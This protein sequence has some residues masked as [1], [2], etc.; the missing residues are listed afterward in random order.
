MEKKKM[1]QK[2]QPA[3]LWKE[4]EGMSVVDEQVE[5]QHIHTTSGKLMNE[6]GTWKS[7]HCSTALLLPV[8]EMLTKDESAPSIRPSYKSISLEFQKHESYAI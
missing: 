4:G 1:K 2:H 5:H 8:L 6:N 3:G 7:P